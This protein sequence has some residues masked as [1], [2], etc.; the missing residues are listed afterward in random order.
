[1][2]RLTFRHNGIP[3]FEVGRMQKITERLCDIEDILGDDYDLARLRELVTADK[4]GRCKVGD[5]VYTV[6]VTRIYDTPIVKLVYDCGHFAFDE[7]AIG[8]T[9]F[10]TREAAE[11]ALAKEGERDG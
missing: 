8:E 4:D 9:V 1:M 10:L 6:D 3:L 2:E 5:I 7:S 11:A